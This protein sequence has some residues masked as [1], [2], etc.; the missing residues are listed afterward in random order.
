MLSTTK[1]GGL[2]SDALAEAEARNVQQLDHA[3]GLVLD[4]VRADALVFTAGAGH[5]L[6]AVA[7]TFYRAG[8]LAAVYPIYHPDLLPL[9][10]ARA[11]TTAERKPGLAAQVLADKAPGAEDVL[12]VFSSPG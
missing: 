7:E 5:S 2:V 12:V 4:C 9:H 1:I 10:G 11:S 8:G 6:A 3:A